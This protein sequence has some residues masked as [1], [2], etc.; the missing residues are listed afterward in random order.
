[1]ARRFHGKL[2]GKKKTEKLLRRIQEE[3]KS[4][5]DTDG[6]TPLNTLAALQ[7]KQ[8]DTGSAFMVLARGNQAGVST[9]PTMSKQ[10]KEDGTRSVLPASASS[11][12]TP[13]VGISQERE[14]LSFQFGKG[15]KRSHE[16][17]E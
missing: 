11:A 2:P 7:Q 13:L 10:M 15:T 17:E 5:M 8:Q 1:M 12:A 14:R 3:Q 16:D 4:S 6:D 9:L